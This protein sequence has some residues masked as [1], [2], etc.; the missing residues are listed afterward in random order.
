VDDKPTLFLA[1][2]FGTSLLKHH[3]QFLFFKE[4]IR[5]NDTEEHAEFDYGEVR[6]GL[7]PNCARQGQIFPN[8]S[9][10]NQK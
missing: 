9:K 3:R 8:G 10:R 7:C 6:I 5:F 4:Q 1:V 2:F